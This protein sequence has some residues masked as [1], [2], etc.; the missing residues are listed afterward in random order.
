M[1]FIKFVKT[2]SCAVCGSYEVDAH[3]L[4][5]IGMGGNRKGDNIEDFSCVPLCRVH[6]SEWHQTGDYKFTDKYHINLWRIN[7]QMNKQWRNNA[8]GKP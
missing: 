8:K 1:T 4:D 6:H 2:F 5:T 3:H 7:Y